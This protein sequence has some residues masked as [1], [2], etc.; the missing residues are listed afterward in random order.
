[1]KNASQQHIMHRPLM[2]RVLIISMRVTSVAPRMSVGLMVG[3]AAGQG[4]VVSPMRSVIGVPPV[5]LVEG[6]ANVPIGHLN[7]AMKARSPAVITQRLNVRVMLSVALEERVAED[8]VGYGHR[9]HLLHAR[10]TASARRIN[11]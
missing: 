1:M 2:Y 9:Q 6:P 10:T 11:V 7:N 3:I 5:V 4:L 8:V